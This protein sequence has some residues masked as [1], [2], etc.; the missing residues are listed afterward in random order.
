[1]IDDWCYLLIASHLASAHGPLD[2]C[3]RFLVPVAGEPKL[4]PTDVD[5]SDS[6]LGSNT[7]IWIGPCFYRKAYYF[8]LKKIQAQFTSVQ[9]AE[10]GILPESA[11]HHHLQVT[12][13]LLSSAHNT[14][15]TGE[16]VERPSNSL[17]NP[18]TINSTRRPS[19]G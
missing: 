9:I 18:Q 7:A 10:H 1:M 13:C 16:T 2:F 14:E 4:C 6:L 12:E 5:R 17:A 19:E 3:T 11:S 15:L 8:V